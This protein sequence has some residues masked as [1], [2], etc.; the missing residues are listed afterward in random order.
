MKIVFLDALTLGEDIDLSGFSELGEVEI[1]G[2]SDEAQIR[3]RTRDAD[4]I[5]QTSLN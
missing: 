5:I 3:E 2:T 1:Y 4:V